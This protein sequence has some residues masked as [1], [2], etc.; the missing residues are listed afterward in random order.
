[1]K[2]LFLSLLVVV[3]AGCSSSTDPT[4][5]TTP[6]TKEGACNGLT[7]VGERVTI[8]NADTT[9]PLAT[10][11]TITDGT[12]VL[13]KATVHT[14]AGGEVGA[15]SETREM[16][17]RVA[18]GKAESVFDGVNRSATI[19]TNGTTLH[20]S[21]TCPSSSEEHQPFSA[22]PTTFSIHSSRAKGTLVLDFVKR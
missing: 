11:G 6:P 16:T 20:T 3:V 19:E 9:P 12:Y 15:T 1:M 14:G 8:T 21:G 4:D 18:G 2:K 7:N 5:A 10:G 13:T 17:V 22:T